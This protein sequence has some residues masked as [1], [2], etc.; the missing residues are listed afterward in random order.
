M[1]ALGNEALFRSCAAR[2]AGLR[3][4]QPDN[5]SFPFGEGLQM[6]YVEGTVVLPK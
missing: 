5:A 1:R 3:A 2:C 6:H 4:P